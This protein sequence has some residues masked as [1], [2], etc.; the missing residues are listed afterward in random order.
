[1]LRLGTF[2]SD[3]PI[4]FPGMQARLLGRIGRPFGTSPFKFQN[5]IKGPFLEDAK[6]DS[7]TS[8]YHTTYYFSQISDEGLYCLDPSMGLGIWAPL[9]I[10]A[11]P[12]RTWIESL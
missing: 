9:N 11:K 5:S 8:C 7:A 3:V 2:A 6:V 12:K 1:M 10:S 4:S